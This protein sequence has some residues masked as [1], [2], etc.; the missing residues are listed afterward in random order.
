MF[1][2]EAEES[3]RTSPDWSYIKEE[4]HLKQCLGKYWISNLC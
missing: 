2:Q 3:T 1:K 4:S